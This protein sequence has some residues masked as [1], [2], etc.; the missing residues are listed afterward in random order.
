MQKVEF[1][2]IILFSKTIDVLNNGFNFLSTNF[3]LTLIKSY[4]S[5]KEL[6]NKFNLANNEICREILKEYEEKKN[7]LES[8]IKNLKNYNNVSVGIT[9]AEFRGESIQIVD[10]NENTKKI[11][12]DM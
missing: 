5:P 12:F 7:E 3:K 1:F 11:C 2:G 9:P 4:I 6:E 8:K 10:S